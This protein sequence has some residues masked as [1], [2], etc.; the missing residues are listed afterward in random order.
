MLQIWR[1]KGHLARLFQQP[2]RSVLA[3]S[4]TAPLQALLGAP[5]T[6]PATT[7]QRRL[8]A[9]LCADVAGYTRLMRADER[10]TLRLLTSHRE[11]T[12]RE[13]KQHGGRIANTAGDS[14][15][16]EFPN[17]MDAVQ[18]A[19]TIQDRVADVNESVPEDRRVAFRI[20]VHVG[21]A[22]V[23]NGDLFGD[24]VNVA[25]RLESLAPAGAICLSG[26]THEYIRRLMT[27][28]VFED[29]GPVLVKN[30]DMPVQAFVVHPLGRRSETA[31]PAVHGHFEFHLVRRVHYLCMQA[32]SEIG[33]SAGISGIDIPA[34]ASIIDAPGLSTSRLA[35]RLGLKPSGAERC[36]ARLEQRGLISRSQM[37]DGHRSTLSATPEGVET[38]LKLRA[39]VI[40]A[41]D[42]ILAPL[43]EQERT[44][45]KGLLSRVIE[46]DVRRNVRLASAP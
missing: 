30:V 6:K 38:R 19:L 22:M 14:I 24:G 41:Q 9:F 37:A 40:V 31:I 45:L 34:L 43:S 18:C 16:A 7:V 36:V 17:A 5:M 35:E 13:I 27:T 4:Q 11:I 12:D 29:L 33:K 44:V 25:A 2:C 15:L 1:G 26:S 23:R 8:A 3:S 20:G 32:L 42:R 21:E 46:A 10:A 39:A 28:L